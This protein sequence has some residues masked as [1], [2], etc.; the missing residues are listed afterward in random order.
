M[1]RFNG[2]ADRHVAR[3]NQA[4]LIAV[5]RDPLDSDRIR[6]WLATS[7]KVEV[8]ADALS[9]PEAVG[10]IE[11][12]SPDLLLIDLRLIS[13]ATVRRLA[14]SSAR[15][16]I[17]FLNSSGE[18]CDWDGVN[19][20]VMV[21]LHDQ[22][23]LCR[24]IELTAELRLAAGVLVT[25][26]RLLE[27]LTNRSFRRKPRVAA[28]S[29]AFLDPEQISWLEGNNS[30]TMV[31]GNQLRVVQLPMAAILD[32]FRRRRAKFA[33]VSET[34]AINLARVD[35]AHVERGGTGTVV[36]DD[37]FRIGIDR[38]RLHAIFR[39]LQRRRPAPGAAPR[40]AATSR[41]AARDEHSHL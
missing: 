25:D 41:E 26:A 38:E 13:K 5:C 4:R 27:L 28:G 32:D 18:P 31:Y 6:E 1:T 24:Q 11:R 16:M 8:V 3:R 2:K 22:R 17:I 12:H 9:V 19:R 14:Y 40:L 7:S 10:A 20:A 23:L 29:N 15:A 21:A 33:L 39:R 37:G 30:S 36:L 35:A 34:I